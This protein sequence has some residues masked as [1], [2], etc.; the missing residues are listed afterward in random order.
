VAGEDGGAAVGRRPLFSDEN[1]REKRE[2]TERE[3]K[4]F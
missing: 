3:R 2:R 4:K 1:S